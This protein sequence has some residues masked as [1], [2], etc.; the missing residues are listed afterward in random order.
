MP[1]FYPPLGGGC[2]FVSIVEIYKYKMKL[3][4]WGGKDVDFFLPVMYSRA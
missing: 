3:C 1:I 2:F 4:T